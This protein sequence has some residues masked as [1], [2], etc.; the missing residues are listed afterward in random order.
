MFRKIETLQNVY[1]NALSS[2]TNEINTIIFRRKEECKI[3]QE[4]SSINNPNQ[5]YF[6]VDSDWFINWKCFVTND[7]TEKTLS[8]T[9]KR[10]SPNTSIGVLPPGPITNS[11]LFDKAVKDFT[12]GNLRKGIK[13]VK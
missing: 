2:T 13:K 8:N 5:Q 6:A 10:L 7:L 4:L 11:N 9:K 1:T 12:E 3:F